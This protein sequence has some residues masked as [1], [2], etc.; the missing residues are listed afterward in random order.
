MEITRIKPIKYRVGKYVLNEL[1]L[2]QLCIEVV[3]G[4][5]P[6]GIKVTN[7]STKETGFIKSNG[8]FT[9]KVIHNKSAELQIKLLKLNNN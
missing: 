7:L 8:G 6:A 2:R 4:L 9:S 3:Q 5:K 1:E